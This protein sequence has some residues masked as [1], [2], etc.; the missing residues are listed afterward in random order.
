MA[1]YF[2]N[3]VLITK[4]IGQVYLNLI[5]GYGQPVFTKVYLNNKGQITLLKEFEGDANNLDLGFSDNLRNK[6]LEIH[7]TVHD[8]RDIDPAKEVEDIHLVERVNCNNISVDT[9]FIKRTKGKGEL[10]NCYYNVTIF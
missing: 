3:D 8:I 6:I 2:D 10:V 1:T 4:S 7:S 9:T 5:C